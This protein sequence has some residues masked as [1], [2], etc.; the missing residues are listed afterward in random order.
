M[1]DL[2]TEIDNLKRQLAEISDLQSQTCNHDELAFVRFPIL[3]HVFENIRNG[4]SKQYSGFALRTSKQTDKNMESPDVE[5]QILASLSCSG[6]AISKLETKSKH[7]ESEV[8]VLKGQNET[9]TVQLAASNANK[10]SLETELLNSVSAVSTLTQKFESEVSELTNT[11]KKLTLVNNTLESKVILME[12]ENEQA[13]SVFS[14]VLDQISLSNDSKL[15]FYNKMQE[16]GT[17]IVEKHQTIV[18]EAHTKLTKMHLQLCDKTEELTRLMKLNES[19]QAQVAQLTA[20]KSILEKS[21][22]IASQSIES[23][24]NTRTFTEHKLSEMEED[25]QRLSLQAQSY[26]SASTIFQSEKL[27]LQSELEKF[28]ERHSILESKL[29]KAMVELDLVAITRE[30]Y[31]NSASRLEEL[32]ELLHAAELDLRNT[33]EAKRSALSSNQLLIESHSNLAASLQ[34][35]TME[36]ASLSKTSEIETLA[37]RGRISFLEARLQ[38]LSASRDELLQLD[39]HCI[40][41]SEENKKLK[42]DLKHATEENKKLKT[43]LKHATQKHDQY[44]LDERNRKDVEPQGFVG[45]AAFDAL[46]VA[47]DRLA[48]QLVVANE[49]ISALQFNLTERMSLEE[50]FIQS[51]ETRASQKMSETFIR[52]SQER[53]N[54]LLSAETHKSQFIT[55]QTELQESKQE[56]RILTAEHEELTL[57]LLPKL[58]TNFETL[59]LKY[60]RAESRCQGLRSELEVLSKS[61]YEDQDDVRDFFQH[62][63]DCEISQIVCGE[64]NIADIDQSVLQTED[65]LQNKPGPLEQVELGSIYLFAF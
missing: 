20:S 55:L 15:L 33:E 41:L 5:A 23:E 63:K 1:G 18:E 26:R 50:E 64:S 6:E 52:L 3:F 47:H 28:G 65:L 22:A 16:L 17:V 40:E 51:I 27:Q 8:M 39:G 9:L 43:D 11:V 38:E 54:A 31:S 19:L 59:Q 45:G 48:A 46:Q 37:L 62:N 21:L 35:S 56:K 53:D 14:A 32:T 12:T 57:V 2:F 58:L 60:T 36:F 10:L 61:F 25:I 24:K 13:K 49:S 7:L 34:A 44:L 30:Q 4:F 29:A 42:I